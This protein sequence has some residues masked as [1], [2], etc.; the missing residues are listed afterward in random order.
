MQAIDV[1]G[2]PK[3][4]DETDAVPEGDNPPPLKG[5][6]RPILDVVPGGEW[7][8]DVRTA[9][10]GDMK[11]WSEDNDVPSWQMARWMR[12][13]MDSWFNW[14]MPYVLT[15]DKFNE[16]NSQI[17]EGANPSDP[18]NRRVEHVQAPTV[19][20]LLNPYSQQG[21]DGIYNLLKQKIDTFI[22]GFA[23]PVPTRRP[24]SGTR[25]PTAGEIRQQFDMQQLTN[26]AREMGQAYLV[27]DLPDPGGI[28]KAYVDRVVSTG[29]KQQI[30]Y[31]TFVLERLKKT[32]RWKQIQRGN[33]GSVDPLQYVTKYA[34]MAQQVLGGNQGKGVGA[35]AA[36]GAALGGSTGSFEARL[37]REDA[38]RNQSTFIGELEARM[39]ELKGILRG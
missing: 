1:H 19:N 27:E 7:R 4:V 17:P 21:L 10:L 5:D 35:V 12:E 36:E 38:V 8:T 20:G 22:P 33:D 28:A 32:A 31:N 26:K 14:V 15:E 24:G 9:L 16:I 25:P 30:D 11:T 29:G 39:S 23:T 18:Q 13:Q 37:R 6:D 34:S 3:E 2:Q